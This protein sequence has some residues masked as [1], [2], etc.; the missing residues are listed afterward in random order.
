MCPAHAYG[1]A[2]ACA[3]MFI[4]IPAFGFCLETFA[5]LVFGNAADSCSLQTVRG[6][7][8][9]KYATMQ[10]F[11]DKL[12]AIG[13]RNNADGSQVS[14]FEFLCFSLVNNG[15]TDVDSIESIMANFRE[16][17]K[18][19]NGFLDIQ[20]FDMPSSAQTTKRRKMN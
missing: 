17:D 5:K 14:R 8:K 7:T 18:N 13:A 3:L 11:C 20:D 6:L 9:E 1:R 19:Q 4:G 12:T 15:V 2:F 10:S 16:L